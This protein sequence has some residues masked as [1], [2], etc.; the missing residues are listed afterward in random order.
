MLVRSFS[1][2]RSHLSGFEAFADRMR[3]P[4]TADQTSPSL[5]RL[6]GEGTARSLSHFAH[7]ASDSRGKTVGRAVPRDYFPRIKPRRKPGL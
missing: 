4:C 5:E 1:G 7:F 6:T 3:M 2:K